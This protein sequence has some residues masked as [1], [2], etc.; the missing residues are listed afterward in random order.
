M[1]DDDLNFYDGDNDYDDDDDDDDAMMVTISMM[2]MMALLWVVPLFFLAH[3]NKF[4]RSHLG[5]K[6]YVDDTDAM[7]LMLML[8]LMIL[9][10]KYARMVKYAI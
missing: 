5:K 1:V 8:V 4:S 6:D 3:A 9:I 10:I 2:M 7:I